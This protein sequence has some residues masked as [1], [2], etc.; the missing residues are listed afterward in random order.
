MGPSE[1]P[2]GIIGL[3]IRRI[4]IELSNL[5]A[6]RKLPVS[7]RDLVLD[8]GSG[9][10]P[11][12]R[13]DVL[14]DAAAR[15][16]S[17]RRG[18]FDLIVDGRPFLYTDARRIPV[19]DKAF[20]FVICRHVLEHMEEPE[21]LL[22][23]LMRVGKAGYIETPSALMERLYG[24]DFHVLLVESSDEG[25]LI[26]R[27]LADEQYGILPQSIKK[28]AVWEKLYYTFEDTLAACYFWEDRIDY[29]IDD[30]DGDRHRYRKA[31]EFVF[32]DRVELPA[33]ALRRRMRWWI[34]RSMR[35]FISAPRWNMG[36]VLACPSCGSDFSVG[37]KSASC[38]G[39]AKEVTI[40]RG[41]FF[42]F[43]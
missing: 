36:E 29:R 7:R 33:P 30:T 18:S 27:K 6:W 22:K 39:C 24:W 5:L 17:E 37:D 41:N 34:T 25:L 43:I 8:V 26:R 42:K 38:T 3:V 14:C 11:H 12:I 10:N 23:E 4:S 31:Q 1:A 21:V 16:A 15:S 35:F 2:S 28:S 40:L 13:A 32:E 19:K 9:D 20:D